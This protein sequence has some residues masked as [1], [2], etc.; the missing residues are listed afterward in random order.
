MRYSVRQLFGASALLIAV[1]AVAAQP[2]E[3]LAGARL[4][5]RDAI[6]RSLS[7]NLDLQVRE[8]A[9]L[10]AQ[11]ALMRAR[12]EFDPTVF[13]EVTYENVKRQQ[14]TIEFISTGGLIPQQ[15]R[16][17]EENLR[18]RAGIGGRLPTGGSYELFAS[19]AELDNSVN[20]SSPAA[21]FHPEYQSLLGFELTQPVLQKF[22]PGAS[23]V[24][25]RIAGLKL[26]VSEFERE[27]Q[28]TNKVIEV[29]NAYHDLVF[30]QDNLR[31][32]QEAE[33]SAAQLYEDNRRREAVGRMAPLDV[34]QADVK[35]SEAREE[36]LLAR[37][38][39]RERRIVLL[40]LISR[41]PIGAALPEFTVAPEFTGGELPP[42]ADL[43]EKAHAH[44]PD[45]LAAREELGITGLRRGQARNAALPRL[46]LKFTYGL[47]GLDRGWGDTLAR[48]TKLHEPQ[49]TGGLVMSA[50]IGNRAARAEAR[51]AQREHQQA[52]LRL[53][54]LGLNVTLDIHN[55]VQRLELQRQRLETAGSSRSVAEAALTAEMRRLEAGQTTSFNV[56]Q[57]QDKV[58]AARTRELAAKV[59]VQKTIAE[60]WAASGGLFEHTGFT[61]ARSAQA[62]ARADRFNP[63]RTFAIE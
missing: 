14:N 16:Y 52:Q 41:A 35:R 59:D 58:S 34:A 30:G 12:A 3:T 10:I 50:P 62:N 25:I 18:T 57:M 32:K 42:V 29:V 7:E 27:L 40:K 2:A 8:M 49:W 48:A 61:F 39:L 36:V 28:V 6:R 45:Y 4:T 17:E 56:L 55:A 21:L 19:G 51:A 22:G 46:D 31:V 5:L 11:D 44:R 15:G 1:A 9:P 60:V 54:E 33:A 20:R 53:E 37:D 43:V 38:F 63:L 26:G 13:A 24:E 23:L 47:N